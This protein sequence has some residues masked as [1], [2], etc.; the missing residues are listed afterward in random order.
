MAQGYESRRPPAAIS[1]VERGETQEGRPCLELDGVRLEPITSHVRCRS[2]DA[3]AALADVAANVYCV[4]SLSEGLALRARLPEG[5]TLVTPKGDRLTSRSLVVW[6]ASDPGQSVLFASRRSPHSG[7]AFMSLRTGWASLMTT[8][9]RPERRPRP[10][11][12]PHALR[13][14]APV[15]LR[16]GWPT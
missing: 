13:L 10:L 3:T 1:F 8:G 7:T 12:G 11:N 6:T 9:M 5:V 2:S 14:R 16:R 4:K 15:L